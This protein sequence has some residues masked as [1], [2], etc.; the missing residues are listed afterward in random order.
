MQKQQS[1]HVA[2]S[3]IGSLGAAFSSGTAPAS[4]APAA[5]GEAAHA[6]T[7]NPDMPK[8]VKH[9]LRAVFR[10]PVYLYGAMRSAAKGLFRLA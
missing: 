3:A 2:A 6:L 5:P 9:C 10:Q 7:T 8:Q 4:A 1:R